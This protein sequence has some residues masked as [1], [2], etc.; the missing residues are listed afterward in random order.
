MAGRYQ[1][2]FYEIY[3]DGT[4][5]ITGGRFASSKYPVRGVFDLVKQS[6]S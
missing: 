3:D 4:C 1:K 6:V 5:V 2:T